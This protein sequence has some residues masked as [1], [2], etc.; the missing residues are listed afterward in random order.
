VSTSLSPSLRAIAS[1]LLLLASS[2]FAAPKAI[3]GGTLIDGTGRAPISDAVILIERDRVTWSGPRPSAVIP[4]HAIRVDARGRTIVPGLMDGN[5]HLFSAVRPDS[6]QQYEGRFEDLIIE[7]AQIELKH[8]VTTV[9]DT[10][11]PRAALVAARDRIDAGATPGSRI[12]VGGNIIGMSGPATKLAQALPGTLTPEAAKR[13]DEL[14]EQ[15]VGEDLLWRTPQQIGT[16]VHDYIATGHLDFIKYLSSG[17]DRME[18]I[19]FS[20]DAQNAI[21][22]EGHHAGLRVQAHVT[23]PESL[24]MAIIAGVDLLQHCDVSGYEPIPAAT[25]DRIAARRIPCAAMF[26]TDARLAWEADHYP[27]LLKIVD[28]VQDQNDRALIRDGALVAMA[29][30]AG[31]PPPPDEKADKDPRFAQAQGPDNPNTFPHAHVLWLRAA[32][33]KG[34]SPMAALQ[35]ATRNV[36]IAYGRENDLG[37]I[38]AGKKADL[39]ILDADPLADP[40]NYARVRAVYKDGAEIDVAALPTRRIISRP[41]PPTPAALHHVR[42]P[43]ERSGLQLFKSKKGS[44]LSQR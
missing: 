20:P 22:E 17:H 39:V 42:V 37:T 25:L 13:F 15:G 4:R 43:S 30:D 28:K 24:K 36:A 32:I 38:E 18:M 19:A 27:E 23:S 44:G 34:M 12:F 31:V 9:F 40:R 5:V 7:A 1:T 11:G 21:V 8:G 33:E 26:H 10:W 14:W 29:T 6:L 41:K 3:V 35:S 16:A 2:A